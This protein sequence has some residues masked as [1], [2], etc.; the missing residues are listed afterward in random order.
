MTKQ[1]I[2]MAKSKGFALV[3]QRKHYV[4]KHSSGKILVCSKTISDRR[5]WANIQA[6]ISKL[7]NEH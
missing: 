4:F 2:A 3:R 1:L 5:A 6:N 7:L